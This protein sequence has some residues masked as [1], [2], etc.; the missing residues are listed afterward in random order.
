MSVGAGPRYSSLVL[1]TSGCLLGTH[2]KY[3]HFV[4]LQ[5]AAISYIVDIDDW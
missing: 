4:V 2:P 3:R 5:L 1:I